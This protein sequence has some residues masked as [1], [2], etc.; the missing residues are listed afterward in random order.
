MATLLIVDDDEDI[1]EFLRKSLSAHLTVVEAADGAQ[2]VAAARW[3]H[4]QVVVM[5]L[6]MPVMDGY[7]AARQIKADATTGNPILIAVTGASIENAVPKARAAGF[8]YFIHKE[9][10][11]RG[12]VEKI[13]RLVKD[14]SGIADDDPEP[15][16]A[17]VRAPAPAA[18]TPPKRRPTS[19]G[20][21]RQR[22]KPRSKKKA[23]AVRRKR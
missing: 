4:P 8:S 6:E 14:A 23:P 22:A 3:S 18:Q 11:A 5:D 16:A 19:P 1:R 15:A 20:K 13:V 21:P 2:A 17:P 9:V 7:E 10:S 12:F